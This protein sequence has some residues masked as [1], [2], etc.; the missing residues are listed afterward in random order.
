[1]PSIRLEEL[2]VIMKS[3]TA[4]AG[5]AGWN[6][7]KVGHFRIQSGTDITEALKG[8]PDDM[9]QCPHWGLVLKGAIHLRYSDGT[10]EVIQAGAAFYMPP[11]HTA[12]FEQDT[13][14]F[15][16]SPEDEF[17]AVMAHLSK[18]SG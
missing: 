9:C 18:Q 3:D 6:G 1:M 11:G 7:M 16:V 12:W 15:E 8:L 13:E 10:T 4:N 5:G 14:H 17:D 2:P